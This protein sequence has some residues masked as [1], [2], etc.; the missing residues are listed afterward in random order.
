MTVWTFMLPFW[1]FFAGLLIG[2]YMPQ[3]LAWYHDRQ[4]RR[5]EEMRAAI[6]PSRAYPRRIVEFREAK[7]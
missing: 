7:K 4:E 6:P 1:A 2:V 5:W 3:F